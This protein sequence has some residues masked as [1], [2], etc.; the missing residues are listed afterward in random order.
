MDNKGFILT[1]DAVLTLIPVFIIIFTVTNISETEMSSSS[2]HIHEL[3]NA[4]DILETMATDSN[5]MNSNLFQEMA[6]V[7]TNDDSDT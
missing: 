4:Q 6:I 1:L 7:L 5:S 3:Q 2:D